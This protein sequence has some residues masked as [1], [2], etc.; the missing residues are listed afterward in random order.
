MSLKELMQAIRQVRAGKK[1]I[2]PEVAACLAEDYGDE[3]GATLRIAR[4]LANESQRN[5]A[6]E[7]GRQKFNNRRGLPG[8][9]G[10]GALEDR[11]IPI[12]ESLI[13]PPKTQ[14]KVF[15][16]VVHARLHYLYPIAKFK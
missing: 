9:L 3:N 16:L 4:Q 12:T 5:I 14:E 2:P 13:H 8:V 10:P 7:A 11:L 6:I 15:C 1:S